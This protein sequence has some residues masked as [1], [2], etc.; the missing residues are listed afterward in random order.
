MALKGT[1]YQWAWTD[2]CAAVKSKKNVMQASMTVVML[3]LLSMAVWVAFVLCI[4]NENV[5]SLQFE[6]VCGRCQDPCV[7]C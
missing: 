2:C 1:E 4:G 7:V 6:S 5:F 3:S